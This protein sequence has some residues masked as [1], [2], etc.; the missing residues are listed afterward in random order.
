M[1]LVRDQVTAGAL[2]ESDGRYILK[3]YAADKKEDDEP[4]S[5]PDVA[6]ED[7]TK[8]ETKKEKIKDQQK[9]K[10]VLDELKKRTPQ[11]FFQSS[12][13][14]RIE[15]IATE[16]IKS[17]LVYI[18][19]R[20]SDIESF[21]ISLHSLQYMK[22]DEQKVVGPK[23]PETEEVSGPPK[24]TISAILTIKNKAMPDSDNKKFALA[25]FFVGGS[26]EVTTSD[27]I[28]GEDDIVYG[29]TEQGLSQYFSR[30]KFNDQE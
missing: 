28:K 22:H 18:A 14:D 17:V 21:D 11:E 15:E 8:D 10:N 13:P 5:A 30:S 29:F 16:H 7:E 2:S 23:T 27:S 3:K 26:G 1:L 25:V 20:E 12:L 6:E 9:S 4:V 24:A 19:N